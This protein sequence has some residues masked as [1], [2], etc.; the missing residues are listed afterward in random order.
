MPKLPDELFIHIWDT[1]RAGRVML[2]GI[3]EPQACIPLQY[4]L[5]AYLEHPSVC[6]D[7][8]EVYVTFLQPGRP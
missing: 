7:C 3:S 8:R 2:C 6:P 4:F 5:R 1:E